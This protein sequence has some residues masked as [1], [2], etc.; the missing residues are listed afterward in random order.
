MQATLHKRHKMA[1]ILLALLI[2]LLL[3]LPF[4]LMKLDQINQE[5]FV[6]FQPEPEEQVAQQQSQPQPEEL[7]EYILS[8]G[9]VPASSDQELQEDMAPQENPM[10][11]KAQPGAQIEEEI[12]QESMVEQTTPEEQ[13]VQEPESEPKPEIE[14]TEQKV[15]EEQTKEQLP[16]QP[17]T[18]IS[19]QDIP[20]QTIVEE[21]KSE[22]VIEEP[23]IEE[24]RQLVDKPKPLPK[25]E[26]K[27]EQAFG[28]S[29]GQIAQ[30]FIKSVQQEEG[31][32]NPPHMDPD[33]L[34]AHQYATKVWNIIKNSFRSD[35][36][37]LH[38]SQNIDTM[39]YLVITLTKKGKL[40]DIHLEGNKINSAFRQIEAMITSHAKNAGLFPPLPKRFNVP[41][42]TF[43]FP[44]HIQGHEGF[45][46]Y[47]LNYGPNK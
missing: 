19:L 37:M 20:E 15:V 32:N 33:K 30:G 22:P 24:E 18:A 11:T 41:Q 36:N 42:K 31:L 23:K 13:T 27:K 6:I 8:S 16:V 40:V 26:P 45:H 34:A 44:L 5:A 25:P 9:A 28:L 3:I 38:L 4:I 14:K 47:R 43:T 29:L 17:E 21:K 1:I 46:S 7:I 12:E 2:N 39:A 10:L 35:P